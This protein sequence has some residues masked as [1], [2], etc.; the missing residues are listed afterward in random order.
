MVSVD[1]SVPIHCHNTGLK[2]I[3]DLKMEWVIW[4]YCKPSYICDIVN[5]IDP[6]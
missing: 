1:I 6:I 4:G 2:L 5:T 3:K